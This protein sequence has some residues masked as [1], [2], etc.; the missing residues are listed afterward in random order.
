MIAIL[1]DFVK[2]MV[3]MKMMECDVGKRTFVTNHFKKGAFK[4]G[5]NATMAKYI[6]LS[7]VGKS[8][9]M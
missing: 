2:P 1:V 7:V 6:L 4:C 9:P 8:C 5:S 3:G